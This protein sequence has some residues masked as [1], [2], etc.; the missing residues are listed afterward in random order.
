M[1]PV[2]GLLLCTLWWVG[3]RPAMDYSD[4]YNQ[5]PAHFTAYRASAPL[6]IDGLVEEADWE[7]APRSAPFVDI[8]TGKPAWFDTRV[9][10][11]WDDQYL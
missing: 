5:E 9:S 3:Q 6:Q 4:R 2:V 11:L 1:H 10:I 8:V 7:R